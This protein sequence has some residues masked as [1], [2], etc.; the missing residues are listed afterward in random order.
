MGGIC[1]FNL[2]FLVFEAISSPAQADF[3]LTISVRI[4]LNFLFSYLHFLRAMIARVH[5]C[6]VYSVLG[7]ELLLCQAST[8]PA[9]PHP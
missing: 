8:L 2:L 5:Q 3:E 7:I 9:K 4:T 6:P 1:S